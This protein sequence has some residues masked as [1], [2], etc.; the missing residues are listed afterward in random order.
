MR[1]GFLHRKMLYMTF[2]Y[3]YATY[4]TTWLTNLL[5]H[6]KHKTSNHL[7][8]KERKW[9][10]FVKV[11][12]LTAIIAWS[13]RGSKFGWQN[14]DEMRISCLTNSSCSLFWIRTFFMAYIPSSA[15]MSMIGEY[16]T[17]NDKK[18]NQIKIESHLIYILDRVFNSQQLK[19]LEGLHLTYPK[20]QVN[21]N[22]I[23]G[24]IDDH[25][26]K[27]RICASA[28]TKTMVL[29]PIWS[30]YQGPPYRYQYDCDT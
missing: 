27:K 25:P 12:T 29:I 8:L 5:D 16:I 30:P 19:L 14:I 6:C 18:C 2:Y 13:R 26:I 1:G 20:L 28:E 11:L 3:D 24:G 23:L 9:P 15:D 17:Q 21:W 7:D 22:W 4:F 10:S